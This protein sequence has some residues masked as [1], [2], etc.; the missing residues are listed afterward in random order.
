MLSMKTFWKPIFYDG[1]YEPD[2]QNEKFAMRK[3]DYNDKHTLMKT[4]GVLVSYLRPYDNK[5]P[6]DYI[7][8]DKY[9]SMGE[10]QE[11]Q[12]IQKIKSLIDF[13]TTKQQTFGAT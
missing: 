3:R 7:K 6:R 4:A 10:Y 12:D 13:K 2:I 9:Y 11:H 8:F 1:Y 5:D